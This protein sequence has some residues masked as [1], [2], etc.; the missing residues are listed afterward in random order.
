M[1]DESKLPKWA[2]MELNKLRADLER[3]EGENQTLR[4]QW[5]KS[6]VALMNR[7]KGNTCYSELWLPERPPVRFFLDGS[8]IG[9]EFY[10]D[11]M[12]RNGELELMGDSS[13]C[14]YPHSSNVAIV[15]A[16]R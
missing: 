2:Q 11:C 14:I 3:S 6:N 1:N 10:V 13:I 4:G 8:G 5:P 7:G 15:K 9:H 12:L 16:A